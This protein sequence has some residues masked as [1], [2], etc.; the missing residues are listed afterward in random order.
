MNRDRP[1]NR[2]DR[3]HAPTRRK[4]VVA[5]LATLA[6][7]AVHRVSAQSLPTSVPPHLAELYEKAKPEGEVAIWGPS[8]LSLEWIPAEF[9]KRFPG[10]KVN[11]LG[12]QQMSSRLIAE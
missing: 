8:G 12:D 1:S 5:A 6:V 7:P 3:S 2:R 11:V 4:V 9:T 10:I